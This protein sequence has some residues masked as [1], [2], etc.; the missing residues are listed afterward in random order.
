MNSEPLVL[1]VEDDK[2]ISALLADYLKTDRFDTAVI[3]RGDQVLSFVEKKEPAL[4]LLDVMLPEKD[5]ITVCRELREKYA[6]P[7]IMLTAR[8]S[9]DDVLNGLDA[10]A[11][12]Y[13]LKPF[14]PKEVVAR[15]KTVLRR[16]SNSGICRKLEVGIFS[17]DQTTQQLWI[18]HAPISLTPTEYG[19]IRSL[20]TAP[21]TIIS[22]KDLLERVQGYQFD[23]YN[24]TIDTHI[25]NLRKKI[26][27]LLPNENVIVSVYGSGYKFETR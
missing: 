10:G 26:S 15:V 24:R 12:D 11:D 6:T 2:K 13:I 18:N 16:S 3:G 4:I 9:E 14:S 8:V 7:V 17:L 19:I 27:G 5:G 25:K 1:I 22:R 21:N 23:G 20:M